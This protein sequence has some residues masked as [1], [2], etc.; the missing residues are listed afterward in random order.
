VDDEEL[1]RELIAFN[2]SKLEN[3]VVV[4]SCASAIEAYSVLQKEA[5]DLM[6]LDIEM[7]LLKG[8]DFY[9]NI[10]VKPQV[11]FT[12]AHR[13]YALNGF[14]LNA[15]DYLLKPVTFE[16]FFQGIEKFLALKNSEVKRIGPLADEKNAFIYIKH[17]RK[18]IK[19]RFD[20]IIYIESV[21][22]YIKIH[23]EHKVIEVKHGLT[24][25]EEKLDSRF[26]RVHRSF[27]INQY[28]ITAYTKKDIEVGSVEIPIGDHYK[29][30]IQRL[31]N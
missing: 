9:K 8:T 22:D 31:L 17:K 14:D 12:T 2:L 10:G 13:E 27:L 30:Q 25:M 16:R 7:P 3:F 26:V 11:I 15:V 18:N 24:A 4:A 28:Y 1:A 21:K 29:E 23:L 20:Q 6:F 5:I 19:L